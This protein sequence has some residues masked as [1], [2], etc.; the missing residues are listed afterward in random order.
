[1]GGLMIERDVFGQ[2]M[3]DY[4][5]LGKR[6]PEIVERDDGYIDASSTVGMYFSEFTDWRECERKAIRYVRG[7][8]L[9]IGCGAGRHSLYL[10]EKGFDVLGVDISPRAIQVCKARGVSKTAVMSMTQLNTKVGVF[11]TVLMLGSNFNLVGSMKRGRQLLKRFERI[12]SQAGRMLAGCNHPYKTTNPHHLEYHDQNR[13]KGRMPGQVRIRIR[14]QKW[15]SRWFDSLLLSPEEMMELLE[16]TNW[17]VERFIEDRS[18]A[19]V[20]I[21]EKQTSQV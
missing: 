2:E 21:L 7:R 6:L 19:Y 9:D 12:T 15:A 3:H 13:K 10:Q 5:F 8:V 20:A 1:M 17:H 16:P 18:S 4:Y 11:D 14:Y